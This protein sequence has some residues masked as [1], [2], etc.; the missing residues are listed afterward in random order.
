MGYDSK[1]N[2]ASLTIMLGLLL[3][4]WMWGF[5]FGGEPTFSC[6][7]LFSSEF[8][9]WSSFRVLAGEDEHMTF[10]SA[11]LLKIGLK[12]T[13]AI[14]TWPHPSEQD[15]VSPTVSF[16]HQEASISLFHEGRQNENHNHRKLIKLITWITALSNSVKLCAMLCRVTQEGRVMWRVL[17]K[18]G[19]LQKGMANHFSTLALR[20]PW[21]V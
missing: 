8:Y 2:I 4:S 9:F 21:T 15:P 12:I 11:I 5:F 17:T 20:T 16:S 3:C 13:G 1:R 7:W 14:S 6:Q 19:P 10:Y 18:C